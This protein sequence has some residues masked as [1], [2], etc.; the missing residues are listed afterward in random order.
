[1]NTPPRSSIVQF[2]HDVKRSRSDRW[3]GGICGGLAACSDIPAWVFRV[4]FI[5]LL[6]TGI[7]PFAYIAL[8]ICMPEE[9]TPSTIHTKWCMRV[10]VTALSQVMKPSLVS[11]A[12]L[13]SPPRRR[14]ERFQ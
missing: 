9:P 2:L 6:P 12:G 10:S 4:I 7:S 3:L 11:S 5:A 13:G 8:W 1:M 14:K